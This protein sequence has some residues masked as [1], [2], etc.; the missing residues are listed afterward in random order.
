MSSSCTDSQAGNTTFSCLRRGPRVRGW[1]LN[2]DVLPLNIKGASR[3]L[4][5]WPS[6]TLDIEPPEALWPEAKGQ[7]ASLA[8]VR[9]HPCTLRAVTCEALDDAFAQLP[10]KQSHGLGAAAPYPAS[11][12]SPPLFFHHPASYADAGRVPHAPR[13][14]RRPPHARRVPDREVHRGVSWSLAAS[15]TSRPTWTPARRPDHREDLIR[16]QPGWRRRAAAWE[17]RWEPCGRTALRFSGPTRTAGRNA[18][19]AAHCSERVR[20]PAQVS[21]D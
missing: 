11:M 20:M 7:A 14:K 21:T 19:E 10:E 9:G 16:K 12:G 2:C 4:R 15:M 5:K 17:P 13:L 8:R 1:P 3:F 18:P 6:A